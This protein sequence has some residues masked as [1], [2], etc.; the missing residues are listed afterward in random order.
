[1]RIFVVWLY[2]RNYTIPLILKGQL[3]ALPLI[4]PTTNPQYTISCCVMQSAI[5]EK[6][7]KPQK[8]DF[9]FCSF[10]PAWGWLGC[11]N[12]GTWSGWARCCFQSKGSSF[13]CLLSQDSCHTPNFQAPPMTMN[14]FVNLLALWQ[15]D[16]I[17][18]TLKA[19]TTPWMTV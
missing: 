12:T 19:S 7:W 16:L 17:R 2:N 11:C 13:S 3:L 8:S 5:A 9:T 6:T 18:L 10:R 4:L 14:L 1:M 15:F